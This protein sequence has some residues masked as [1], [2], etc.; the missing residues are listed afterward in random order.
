MNASLDQQALANFKDHLAQDAKHYIEYSQDVVFSLDPQV[1]DEIQL[2][3]LR[4]KFAA[5]VDGIAI[6]KQMAAQHE[7]T[8]IESFDD[9]LPIFFNQETFRSYPQS[10]LETGDFKRMTKWLV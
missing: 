8:S 10:W 1:L 5:A 3:L 2:G 4:S 7:L 6:I 9:V